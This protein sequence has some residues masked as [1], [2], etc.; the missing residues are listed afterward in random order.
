MVTIEDVVCGLNGLLATMITIMTLYYLD[1]KNQ[2][3]LR[4][5]SLPMRDPYFYLCQCF[6]G[7]AFVHLGLAISGIISW[8]DLPEDNQY[9]WM[10]FLVFCVPVIVFI[11]S[12]PQLYLNHLRKSTAGWSIDAILLDFTGGSLFMLQ[13]GL[14][15]WEV[16]WINLLKF[17]LILTSMIFDILF[18]IQHYYL[19]S[20][21]ELPSVM[22]INENDY[23]S[24]PRA[25]QASRKREDSEFLMLLDDDIT[26]KEDSMRK[27]DSAEYLHGAIDKT[28]K[29][30]VEGYA[31]MENTS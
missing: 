12:L 28:S 20:E 15:D 25:T 16:V 17:V 9:N 5:Q 18:M 27:E 3:T 13:Q 14:R 8:I 19:Y 30:K 29:N 21:K 22:K 31:S 26:R 1:R 6:W 11:K 4:F 2:G 7:A 10:Q 23:L 24:S